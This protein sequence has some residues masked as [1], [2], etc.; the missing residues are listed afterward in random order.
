[1]AVKIR[2]RAQGCVNRKMYRVVVADSRSPRDGKYIEALGWYN[3]T[4]KENMKVQMKPDRLQ[5][6][7]AQG[8][9]VTDR[10]E[11]LMK[12]AAPGVFMEHNTQERAKRTKEAKKRRAKA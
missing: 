10:V 12:E 4:G 1:M 8:A 6:W 9:Q 2:L 3:P 7:I 5:H 11:S